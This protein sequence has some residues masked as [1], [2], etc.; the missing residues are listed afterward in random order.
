MMDG[1]VCYLRLQGLQVIRRRWIDVQQGL[2]YGLDG[3]ADGGEDS[4]PVKPARRGFL[5]A[6]LFQHREIDKEIAT[7]TQCG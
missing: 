3:S 1:S 5:R 6:N 2:A 4:A 7:L